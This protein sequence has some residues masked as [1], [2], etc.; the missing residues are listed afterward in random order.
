MLKT[1]ERKREKN[2]AKTPRSLVLLSGLCLSVA[3]LTVA[4]ITMHVSLF[5]V[6]YSDDAT[7]TPTI[8]PLN[9]LAYNEK[10]IENANYGTSTLTSLATSTASTTPKVPPNLWP[11]KT[12]YPNAGALLP[13]NRIVAYY[14]NFYAKGMGILGQNPPSQMI[15]MLQ[16]EAAKWQAADPST[17]VIPAI[18]YI[19]VVAQG[20]AGA[21]GKYRARMPDSQMDEAVALAAQ[22]HGLVI[23]DVQ[24]GLSNLQTEVP[25]LQKYLKMPQVELAVDPEFAMHNGAKPGTVIGSLDAK[26]INFTANYLAGLVRQYNLPPKILIVHRFTED[27]VTNSDKITPLPEVQLVMDMDGWGPQA[28]KLNTYQ[29]IIHLEPV[30]FTGFKL[31][32]KN[33]LLKPSTGIMTPAQL[34]K[35][36][37]QPLFIQFQ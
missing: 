5:S 17:P 12:V 33:D 6:A 36:K 1:S 14:G 37:P 34:L 11:V 3:V 7:T 22:V 28:R 18:D 24:V 21:D 2:T 13:F 29:Q 25:L 19:T 20:S 32:Y 23:L 26:D 8:A 35:L 27:M 4:F 15:P 31:F 9:I 30:Q 16:M 10:L